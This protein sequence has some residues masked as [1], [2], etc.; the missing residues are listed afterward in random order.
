MIFKSIMH[1]NSLDHDLLLKVPIN[2]LLMGTTI[3]YTY[4]L[5]KQTPRNKPYY[6]FEKHNH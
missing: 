4:K 3:V 6:K 1:I 2:L 5:P